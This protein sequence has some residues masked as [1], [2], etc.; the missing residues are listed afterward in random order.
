MPKPND[1]KNGNSAQKGGCEPPI[2]G[3][4]IRLPVADFSDANRPHVCLEVDFPIAPINALSSLEGNAGKPI[5][6]MSKWWARRRS[7]IF[8][9]LLISASL[10]APDDPSQAQ[11]LVWQHYY[12]NHQKAKNFSK[13]RVLDNFMGGGTTLVE[14]AR[15][16][17][18]M[19]GVDL[20]PVAWFVTKNEVACSDPEQVIQF[21][22][23]IEAEVKPQ[24]QPF[25]TTTCPRG[26]KGRWV[27]VKTGLADAIDPLDLPPAMRKGYRWEGPEVIYTFWAKHGPC[28]SR[29]CSHRTPIFKTPVVA[30]KRLTARFLESMCPKCGT[31]F[32][33]ELGETR[34]APGTELIILPNEPLFTELSRDFANRLSAYSKGNSAE[35]RER[36]LQLVETIRDEPGLRC[37]A[38]NTFSGRKVADILDRHSRPGVTASIIKKTDLGINSRHVYMWLLIHPQWLAGSPSMIDG[39][40]LGGWAGADPDATT[41]W[42]EERLKGLSI[43]EVRGRVRLAEEDAPERSEEEPEIGLDD[44]PTEDLQADDEDSDRKKYGLP[45]EL[46]L[47]DG[48]RVFTR[49]GT[50]P[51]MSYFTCRSCGRAQDILQAVKDTGHT[52]P[53]F[54]YTL[55]CHCPEC[56]DDGTNYGGRYF[57][58]PDSYDLGRLGRAEREWASRSEGDLTSYWPRSELF[59]SFMTHR[60]N[61]GIPNWGYTHWWKMFNARQL[62][63]HT[64]LLR[65]I[66]A[67]PDDSWSLDVKEQ[68]L[69]AFQQYLRMMCMFSFWHR[70]YD[71]LAPSLSNANYHPKQLVVETNVYG[72]LGYGT[73]A[74]CCDTIADGLRWCGNP[75]ELVAAEPGAT[76]K[77]EKV[78]PGDPVL[79]GQADAVCASSTALSR[80]GDGSFDLV[81]TDPPFGN[82]LYYAD[83]SEFF[84]QWLR[85]PLLRWYSGLPEEAYFQPPRT[86]H[87]MEAIDNPLENPDDRESWEKVRFISKPDTLAELQRV[88]GQASLQIGNPNPFYRPE[89]ASDFY[90]T[91]LTSCWAEANRL[92]KPGGLMAF[93]FHHSADAPW[94]DVLEALFDAG[95]LLVAT[96]PIRSDETKGVGGAFGSRKVEYDIIHVCRK[97]LA[98]PTRVSW[99]RMRRWVRDEAQR[100]KDL[101]EHSHGQALSESDL[102][103]ILRGKS[104]EFYIRHY[105][106]VFTSDESEPLSVRY[107]LLG[108]NE[109]LDD[110]L[111][112]A[113]A[114]TRRRPPEVAEPA[115]RLFLRVFQGRTSIGRDDLHKTLRGTGIAQGDFV[116]C[117]WI[118]EAGTT[119]Q[120]VPTPERLRFFLTPGRTRAILKTDL[121]QAHFLIGATQPR[122][123]VNVRDEL[124]KTTFHLK[125]SVDA[126]LQWY[127]ETD[128]SEQIREQAKRALSLVEDWRKK[129]VVAPDG[130]Q[131]TLF[132][133]EE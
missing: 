86:P 43:V 103:V 133:L 107:A 3:K 54:P 124:N 130:K 72:R 80:F 63:V 61:G 122:S 60:L 16:G 44:A 105:G 106:K 40:E 36:V 22:E 76:S 71:K 30:E 90:R 98:E 33:A 38:C 75:W 110:L 27:N 35:K 55:Q 1:R 78:L 7:S 34:I 62:L 66:M 93:T 70:T 132:D 97:R 83:L 69:G 95:F 91:T 14:G 37:P 4:A 115:T 12:A 65:A 116:D 51:Q 18:Q 87:A 41:E 111:Q 113:G 50:V 74:S 29:G 28:K 26:H 19:T 11:T 64:S 101:L 58:A 49:S 59:T 48:T 89:P 47:E 9:S 6:Q 20:N 42:Y 56:A 109:L 15:L 88:N 52:P 100:L 53:V 23:A 99:A 21:F 25:Y 45:K 5:Y 119:I 102:R 31:A 114:E 121:D 128:P 104:L 82:N 39:R 123:G 8:R 67:A 112:G 17:F 127:S 10:S 92:L 81:I 13:L 84:Y 77:S 46:I 129:A 2:L 126:I 57:K 94:I 125:Q 120:V 73:W 24:I 108:I 79:P 131:P 68:A 118:L 96:Y 117:G 85:I 32:N